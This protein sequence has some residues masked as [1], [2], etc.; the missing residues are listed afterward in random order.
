MDF[1]L[2]Q[3][4][5]AYEQNRSPENAERLIGEYQRVLG[6]FDPSV[7]SAR[8]VVPEKRVRDL[9]T[10]AIEGGS[11]HWAM[12]WRYEFAPGLAYDDFREGGRMQ[13]PDEYHHPAELIPFVPGCAV[14]IVDANEVHHSY[15]QLPPD[16]AEWRLD[17]EALFLGLQVMAE[18]H[19]RHMSDFMEENEDAETGDVFLQCCLLG[20]I[21]YG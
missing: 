18:A 7:F 11:R 3:A 2:R 5:R 15:E 6:G 4:Q 16:V 12:I 8:V 13:V 14:I 20:G 21:V 19:P 10:T 1:R 9:L 17:R